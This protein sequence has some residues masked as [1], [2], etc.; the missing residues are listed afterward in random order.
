[1]KILLVNNSYQQFGSTEAVVL[2]EKALLEANGQCVL[3]Y[4]RDNSEISHFSFREKL[5]LPANSIY[6]MRTER[7]IKKIILRFRPDVAYVH[8][9]L[10]LIS[11]SIYHALYANGVPIVQLVHEFRF[12]CPNS[13]FYTQG[14]VCELCKDGNYLHAVRFRCYKNSRL[15]SLMCA[16]TLG[17]NRLAGFLN[18]ISGFICLTEFT[19]QKLME[20]GVPE[21]KLYV[22]PHSINVSRIS[23]QTGGGD[24]L[25]FLG[26][27]SEEKGLVTLVR[28]MAQMKE[29]TLKI[30]GSGPMESYLRSLVAENRLGNVEFLGIKTG[31]E[32]WELLRNCRFVIVPSECYETF[33][34][35]AIE[36]YAMGKP[37][38]G[39]NI[40]SLPYVI[41]EKKTGLL[42]SPGCAEDLREKVNYLW[43]RP[44]ELEAMGRQGR[45]LAETKYSP[46]ENYRALMSIFQSVSSATFHHQVP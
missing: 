5:V 26:R 39:S 22:K 9:F 6:S 27:L 16:A 10:P 28:A 33:C 3:Q 14:R 1:M 17:I 34:L 36:S 18:K 23:P 19:K 35:V 2:E 20:I 25:L 8:N 13:H 44:C 40:G 11:P 30:A 38:I 45:Q 15:V 29:M 7:E 46:D 43:S 31:E 21:K 37:V 4:S 12:L 42:F 24:Y 41:Q 32:K